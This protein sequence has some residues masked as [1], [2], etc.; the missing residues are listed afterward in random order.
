MLRRSRQFSG[1]LEACLPSVTILASSVGDM[2]VIVLIGFAYLCGSVPWGVVLAGRAGVDVR[3]S[4]SGNIGATNVARTAGVRPAI[5]TLLADVAKGFLPTLLARVLLTDAWL[6]AA[7]GLAAFLGHLFSAFLRFSGGKGVAT[8][9]GVFLAL[10][11]EAVAICAVAF[12]VVGLWTRY[13]SLASVIAAGALPLLTL[14]LGARTPIVVAA[15]IS[16]AFIIFRH[17][18]NLLRLRRGTEPKFH[19]RRSPASS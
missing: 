6:I 19:A 16:A 10:A 5:L 3:Q 2:L 8:G 12:A 13:V 7:V 4:G 17:R 1:R 14:M 18:D 11:P 15:L 9:C